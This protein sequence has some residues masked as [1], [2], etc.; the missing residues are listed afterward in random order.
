MHLEERI[1][2]CEICQLRKHT[3]EDWIVCS[4]TDAL[5]IFEDICP[6][7]VEDAYEVQSKK[8]FSQETEVAIGGASHHSGMEKR[9]AGGSFLGVLLLLVSVLLGCIQLLY[10]DGLGRTPIILFMTGGVAITLD[11]LKKHV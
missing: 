9:M 11:V 8:E 1:Q 3:E 5:P 7:F 6:D 10:F 2:Q 4:L